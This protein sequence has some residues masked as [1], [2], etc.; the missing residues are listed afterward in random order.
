VEVDPE[1]IHGAV[2]GSKVVVRLLSQNSD[3]IYKGEVV[4]VLYQRQ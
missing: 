4:E 1:H 3:N 2:D